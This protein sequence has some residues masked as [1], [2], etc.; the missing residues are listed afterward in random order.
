LALPFPEPPLALALPDG[1][2]AAALVMSFPVA[3]AVVGA[4][5]GAWP[6]SSA[7]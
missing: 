6:A 4:A 1:W 7:S 3:D 2:A 5:P